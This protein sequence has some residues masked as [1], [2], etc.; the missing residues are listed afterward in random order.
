M[1]PDK[2]NLYSGHGNRIHDTLELGY[3]PSWRK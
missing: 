3:A 2:G 1:I